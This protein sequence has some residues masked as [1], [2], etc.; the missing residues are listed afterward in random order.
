[1]ALALA[2]GHRHLGRT[3]PNPSVG[4]LV[5]RDRDG[6]AEIVAAGATQPGGRPHAERVALAAAGEA[7]RGATLYVSLEPCSHHGRTPPCAEAV[8]ASG[9]A[10]VVTALEDPDPRVSGRG[11]ALVREA[12]IAVTTGVLAGEARR[13]HAGHIR[14]VRDGRPHL[15]VKVARTADGFSARLAGPRLMISGEA[16]NA[17][18]HL[19]RAHAD[20]I[21]VGSATVQADDPRLDVRLPGLEDRRPVRIV[22]DSRLTL[23]PDSTLART[24]TR[25]PTW[26]LCGEAAAASA[27]A[28]RLR[29]LGVELV[30]V[31]STGDRLDLAAALRELGGRGLTRI[32]CEAGPSLGQALA[33]ADL[34]DEL[35]V[36]TS[37]R[38]LDEPGAPAIGPALAAAMAGPLVLAGEERAGED[39]IK[40]YERPL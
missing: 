15:L 25:Q 5:V 32:L 2:L 31:P 24:A 36:S 26:L 29:A 35:I 39:L 38:P 22:V 10:R 33:E 34:V 1:M 23:P 19:A 20:A 16:C 11:H 30:P 4:A 8:I 18:T 13:A 3:W 27:P 6:A 7:A 9:V 40:R 14:R 28:E 37:A 21:M 12:G 17:R